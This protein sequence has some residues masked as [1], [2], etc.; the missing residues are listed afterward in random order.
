MIERDPST[1][2]LNRR[3]FIARLDTMLI[4][5][6]AD[7]V[8]VEIGNIRRLTAM[9]ELYGEQFGDALIVHVGQ[10]LS[11][12][13]RHGGLA[14]RLSGDE[15][16]IATFGQVA[17]T[18][19]RALVGGTFVWHERT[20]TVD[21]ATRDRAAQGAV[22]RCGGTGGRRHVRTALRPAIHGGRPAQ[23]VGRHRAGP[24]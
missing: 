23:P 10:R 5:R 24:P 16:V 14:A 21:V 3:S 18:T 17:P 8:T 7:T 12:V 11:E 2:L 9:N 6:S 1:E 4:E 19:I 20:A 15:F 13:E 22:Q